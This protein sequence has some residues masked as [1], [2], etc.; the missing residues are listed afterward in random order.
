MNY[1]GS[2]DKP[3]DQVVGWTHVLENIAIASPV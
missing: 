3:I 1:C 2:P